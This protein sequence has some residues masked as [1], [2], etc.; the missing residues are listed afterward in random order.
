MDGAAV[1]S[2]HQPGLTFTAPEQLFADQERE[3][4]WRARVNGLA[5]GLPRSA[6]QRPE[7]SVLGSNRSGTYELWLWDRADDTF[8]QA[9]SRDAGTEH[10]ELS[11]DGEWLWWFSDIGGNEFGRWVRQ[12][13]HGGPAHDV[14]P[15]AGD[16]V[17]SGLALGHGPN[18]PV[19]VFAL[20]VQEGIAVWR[21]FD[22]QPAEAIYRH[23]QDGMSGPL[24]TDATRVAIRH[25]EHGDASTP[26]I[27]V[28]DVA[29][30]HSV[31]E[32]R[33]EGKLLC[34][35]G[36]APRPGDPRL[37]VRHERYGRDE[38][39][40]WDTDTGHQREITIELPGQLDAIWLDADNLAV[41]H[42][43]HG[44][45][46]LH[47]CRLDGSELT[48]IGP[49][50]GCVLGVARRPDGALEYS[51]T[52]SQTATRIYHWTP[53]QGTTLMFP[54]D[55]QAPPDGAPASLDW[56]EGP[57]GPIP[58]LVVRPTTAPT[59]P[60]RTLFW[61]HPGPDLDDADVYS[62][63]LAVWADAGWTVVSTNYRGSTGY[64]AGWRQAIVG[65]PGL[66]ELEDLAAVHDWAIAEGIAD[67]DACMLAGSSWGGYLTLLAAGL[68][69]Q[70]WR[71]GVG[72]VPVT[73]HAMSY[74]LGQEPLRAMARALFGGAPD[75]VPDRYTAASPLAVA[76]QVRA[77]IAIIAG[78]NDTRIPIQQIDAYAEKLAA[79]GRP[80]AVY[81][82]G[83]G[84]GSQV[85]GTLED[86]LRISVAFA[87]AVMHEELGG[88]TPTSGRQPA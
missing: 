71:G 23:D 24:S 44:R 84:H 25:S 16:G 66:T 57:G 54:D 39:L 17:A 58:V 78:Q 52:S 79:L 88:A 36:F 60:G 53:E 80:P 20:A 21:Q 22:G 4:R 34:P 8:R 77:P 64:G 40:L 42:T 37:L 33:D 74:E 18:G 61:L 87:E 29:T 6:G 43:H 2:G 50:E 56:V 75:E 11:A 7:R 65:R 32:M 82:F 48:Q 68:Q 76:E 30:G 70:R 59:G 51:W 14:A 73:D 81:R 47:R 69:P 55:E 72:I 27:R 35:I 26:G 38:L 15:E 46:T 3:S 85:S 12:P 28:L 13:F 67:P 49:D 83:G 5:M 19:A 63:R 45:A 1:A 9:T 41:R 31:A 10:G 62:P 86:F